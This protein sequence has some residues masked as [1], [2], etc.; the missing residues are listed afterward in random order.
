MTTNAPHV[1][2]QNVST[3]LAIGHRTPQVLFDQIF[4]CIVLRN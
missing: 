1:I 3:P 2:K 4:N